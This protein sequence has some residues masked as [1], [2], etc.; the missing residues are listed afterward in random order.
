VAESRHYPYGGERWRDG[1]L[2]TDYHFTSQQEEASL[3]YITSVEKS[4]QIRRFSR[5]E[6]HPSWGQ[7]E[8]LSGVFKLES[9]DSSQELSQ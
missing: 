6:H 8:L 7:T 1:T 9:K 5:R 3:G 4:R 2:P